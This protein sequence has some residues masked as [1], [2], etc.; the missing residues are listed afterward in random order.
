[1][2]VMKI[3]RSKRVSGARCAASMAS[4][5]LPMPPGP[6]ISAPQ[7]Q[8]SGE[9]AWAMA[10]SSLARP[11]KKARAGRVVVLAWAG[12]EGPP[13]MLSCWTVPVIR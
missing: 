9:K 13:V 7:V 3:L 1:M 8:A 12:A 10:S 5:V 6:S 11:T 4:A 2:A